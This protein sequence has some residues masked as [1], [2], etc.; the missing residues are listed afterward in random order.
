MK[1][2]ASTKATTNTQNTTS[3]FIF[4]KKRHQLLIFSSSEPAVL[5]INRPQRK[6]YFKFQLRGNA[7]MKKNYQK[8]VTHHL[9]NGDICW[10][11]LC[12]TLSLRQRRLLFLFF[13]FIQ[14]WQHI[15]RNVLAVLGN[16]LHISKSN[17]A[18]TEDDMNCEHVLQSVNNSNLIIIESQ[19]NTFIPIIWWSTKALK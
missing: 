8:I 17:L 16:G 4:T 10:E 15:Y 11:T 18:N 12:V 14:T 9:I 3:T 1:I 2:N 13:S 5:P 6:C 19:K 7:S